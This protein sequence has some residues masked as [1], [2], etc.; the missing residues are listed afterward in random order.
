MQSNAI[1]IDSRNGVNSFKNDSKSG[2]F[3]NSRNTL[4]Q[5]PRINSNQSITT[6][7]N[8]SNNLMKNANGSKVN[9]DYPIKMKIV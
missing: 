3:N 1:K 4:Q 2:S 5:N 8:V 7:M 9:M 6:P